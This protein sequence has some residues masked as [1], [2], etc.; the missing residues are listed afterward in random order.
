MAQAA[1]LRRLFVA[2]YVVAG[3]AFVVLQ[4]WIVF[5][6]MEFPGSFL[7]LTGLK[8]VAVTLLVEG[9]VGVVAFTKYDELHARAVANPHSPIGQALRNDAPKP[10]EPPPVRDAWSGGFESTD[11]AADRM[12]KG[13]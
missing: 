10:P 9:I 3:I 8:C 2:G 5:F 12:S 7:S 6:F 11:S 1:L 13:R 4:G